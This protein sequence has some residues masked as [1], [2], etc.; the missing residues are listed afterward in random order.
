MPNA[1]EMGIDYSRFSRNHTIDRRGELPV[2]PLQSTSQHPQRINYAPRSMDALFDSMR[3]PQETE[4]PLDRADARAWMRYLNTNWS[5]EGLREDWHTLN[6]LDDRSKIGFVMKNQMN[7]LGEEYDQEALH[8]FKTQTRRDLEGFKLE[9]LTDHNVY[10]RL[11]KRDPDDPSRLV[12]PFYGKGKDGKLIDIVDIVSEEERNGSVKQALAEAKEFLLSAPDGS[13]SIMT[14]PIGPTGFKDQDGRGIDYIDSYFFIKVKDKDEVMN[15]TIK[16]DFK[17]E[18]SRQAIQRLTGKELAEDA[19]LEEYVISLAKIRPGEHPI[20][21]NV[22]DAIDL[23]QS[24]QPE[25]AFQDKKAGQRITWDKVK[26]DIERG[27]DLYNFD[28]EN[29]N[30]LDEFEAFFEGNIQSKLEIEQNTAL[31]VLRMSELFFKNRKKGTPKEI[32]LEPNI[33]YAPEMFTADTISFGQAL[34]DASKRRGCS[35]GGEGSGSTS[36]LSVNTLSPR[37]GASGVDQHGSLDFEC[38]SC[39]QIN[40]RESGVLLHACKH[41]KSTAVSCEPEPEAR[42]EPKAKE[43]IAEYDLAA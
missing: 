42:P 21:N 10:P 43:K 17:L 27:E 41:C 36:L 33:L 25:H 29:K 37:L 6:H 18:Q 40:T 20:V 8:N 22:F 3:F 38:P 39:H 2:V 32:I 19:P 1:I 24:V 30:I 31:A 28:L 4:R 12:D 26:Q 13:M 9:F 14:S 16:T 11:Y 34:R 5:Q 7:M 15:Y 23:L 35:G